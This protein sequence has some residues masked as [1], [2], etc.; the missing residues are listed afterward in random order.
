MKYTALNTDG[1]SSIKIP[2]DFKP[3]E[4]TGVPAGPQKATLYSLKEYSN[5]NGLEGYRA[6]WFIK[7]KT[8]DPH[9]WLVSNLYSGDGVNIFLKDLHGWLGPDFEKFIENGRIAYAKLRGL[10]AD[11]LVKYVDTGRYPQPLARVPKFT[12]PGGLVKR[13]PAPPSQEEQLSYNLNSLN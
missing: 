7:S 5:S 13:E 2:P 8:E 10:E 3:M 6:T 12:A 11:V 1:S 4:F 9:D